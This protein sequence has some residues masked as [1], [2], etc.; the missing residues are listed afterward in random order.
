MAQEKN[1]IAKNISPFRKKGVSL[2]NHLGHS[3]CP[4]MKKEIN[5][6]INNIQKITLC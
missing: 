1:E 6:I 2:Q 5:K 4:L 3:V